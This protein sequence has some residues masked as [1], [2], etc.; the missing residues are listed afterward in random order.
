MATRKIL[1]SP[2]YGA[3]WTSWNTG[4]VAEK[5]LTFQPIIDFLEAGGKNTDLTENHQLIQ[6]MVTEIQAEFGVSYV[7]ILGAQQLRIAEIDGEVK[8]EEY[9]GS[10]SYLTREMDTGWM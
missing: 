4:K 2:G 8:I 6:T 9:D 1:Y 7:C 10:E 5:M 3:G